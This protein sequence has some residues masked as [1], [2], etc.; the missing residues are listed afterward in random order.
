MDE[1]K[2]TIEYCSKPDLPVRERIK[3]KDTLNAFKLDELTKDGSIVIQFEYFALMHV[4]NPMAKDEKEY[5][6]AVIVDSDG[7]HYTTSS[8]SFVRAL[9]D[10]YDEMAEA[11]ET[12]F[13]IE[14]F[15]KPSKN[16]QG[17][18]FVTC[19]LV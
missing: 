8:K 4:V 13:E 6:R 1:F 11:G 2:V 7:K 5:Y 16:Y 17:K 15:Q 12:Q 10:I 3:L 14:V 19:S 9:R 18:N